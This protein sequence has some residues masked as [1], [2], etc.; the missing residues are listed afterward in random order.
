MHGLFYEV[1]RPGESSEHP[2][3]YPVEAEAF[4][5]GAWYRLAMVFWTGE[6]PTDSIAFSDPFRFGSL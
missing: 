4:G 1:I 5:D 6:G 2:V 3:L